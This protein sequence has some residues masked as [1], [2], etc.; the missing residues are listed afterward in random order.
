MPVTAPFV[1]T[2]AR[3]VAAGVCALILLTTAACSDDTD[4]PEAQPAPDVSAFREGGFDEIPRYSRSEPVGTRTS[5]GDVIAQSFKATGA[6]PQDIMDF[7]ETN[8][9]GEWVLE[10]EIERLGVGTYRG[11]WR[12][13][14]HR[15]RV[16]ATPESSLDEEDSADPVIAQYSLTLRTLTE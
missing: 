9:G 8:L 12:N 13:G 11:D 5:E 2:P 1:R 7:Y 4:P 15:L 6:T 3:S 16:S 10:G 14:D